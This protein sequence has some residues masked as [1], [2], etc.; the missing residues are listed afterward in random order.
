MDWENHKKKTNISSQ[1]NCNIK[2]MDWKKKTKIF[3][4]CYFVQIVD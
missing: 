1:T 2:T 4:S 3:S